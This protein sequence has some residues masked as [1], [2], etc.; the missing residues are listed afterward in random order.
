MRAARSAAAQQSVQAGV[1]VGV[2]AAEAEP[3]AVQSQHTAPTDVA[4]AMAARRA[5]RAAATEV[6]LHPDDLQAAPNDS[7]DPDSPNNLEDV[8]LS[9]RV[10][11]KRRVDDDSGDSSDEE[12]AHKDSSAAKPAKKAKANPAGASGSKDK[13]T[14][15][16]TNLGAC[17]APS[18]PLCTLSDALHA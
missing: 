1:P 11:R 10:P 15:K 4:R 17:Y 18:R 2:A 3:A 14:D 16:A 5:Y 8:P 6:A 13:A 9:R 7:D 12:G